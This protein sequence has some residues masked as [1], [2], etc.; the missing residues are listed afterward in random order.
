MEWPGEIPAIFYF[1]IALNRRRRHFF[2]DPRFDFLISADEKL[3]HCDTESVFQ[4]RE[5]R[6]KS[7]FD[8][9]DSCLSPC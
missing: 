8:D 3:S 6:K 5:G 9:L 1:V 2:G 4:R 7:G